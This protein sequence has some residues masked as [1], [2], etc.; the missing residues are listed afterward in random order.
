MFD[1]NLGFA[2]VEC[3]RENDSICTF[4]QTM[5]ERLT[6]QTSDYRRLGHMKT[7][8]KSMNS[9]EKRCD[10]IGVISAS[11]Q[12]EISRED[13]K[14]Y[15][16]TKG[17]MSLVSSVLPSN[18]RSVERTSNVMS[19]QKSGVN[20]QLKVGVGTLQQGQCVSN[21]GTFADIIRQKR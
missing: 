5:D 12:S 18:L 2:R 21:L 20:A 4:N 8:Y 6:T 16:T 13:V 14:R 19:Q 9:W 3:L 11:K 7:P 10:V 15:V 1:Q 17:V